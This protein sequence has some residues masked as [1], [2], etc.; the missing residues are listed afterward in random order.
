MIFW[1]DATPTHH[2]AT[3]SSTLH[4]DQCCPVVIAAMISINLRKICHLGVVTSKLVLTLL[5]MAGIPA[6]KQDSG[7]RA[8]LPYQS[9]M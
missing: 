9:G 5:L 3:G 1:S 6:G 2:T 4:A 7:T 8:L